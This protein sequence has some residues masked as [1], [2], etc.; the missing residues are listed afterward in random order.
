M[1]DKEI[2]F[3]Q[4][5]FLSCLEDIF[6]NLNWN[7]KY[8]IKLDGHRLTNL[9]FA[10]DVIL[11]ARNHKKLQD[12]LQDLS[13]CSKYAGL[14]YE[15]GQNPSHDKLPA[16]SNYSPLVRFAV[17]RRIHIP[18][19]ASGLPTHHGKRSKE[20]NC[21]SMESILVAK[22]HTIGQNIK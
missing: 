4:K 21:S 12:M 7:R 22:I 6:R 5:L 20:E 11:F 16:N 19:S 2:Q 9:R 17:C 15:H 8:G 10:D 18:G 3:R 13:N 14:T 1:C